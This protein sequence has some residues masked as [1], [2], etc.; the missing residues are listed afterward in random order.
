MQPVELH[1]GV[2][3]DTRRNNTTGTYEQI[4]VNSKFISVPIPKTFQFILRNEKICEMMQTFT[5]SDV[6]EDFCD[7]SYF[8]SH[9]LFS[10]LRYALQI[11]LYYDE[12]EC[13]SKK[14]R[15]KVGCLYFILRNLPPELNS[16]LLNI[17]LVSLFHA[18]DAKRYGIDEILK[19]LIRDLK[20]LEADG[21][22]VP[23][24]VQPIY[25]MLAQI[26]GDNLGMHTIFG[27]LESFSAKYFC[28]FCLI[29]VQHSQFSQ[30]MTQV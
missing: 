29:D 23:F 25:G 2:R 12:F 17:H 19:P 27:F 21:I 7:G 8:K 14:G 30:R 1:L 26:T 11:Q 6:Y 15:H 22:P 4:P 3:Y 9:P 16:A 18:Q 10:V 13:G 5:Q 24:A 28:R 20:I